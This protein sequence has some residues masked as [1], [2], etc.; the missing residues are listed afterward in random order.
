MIHF[1]SDRNKILALLSLPL[2]RGNV[3]ILLLGSG[4]KNGELLTYRRCIREQLNGIGFVNVSIME[5]ISNDISDRGIN[6]KFA[7]ILRQ[8][9]PNFIFAFFHKGEKMDAVVFEIGYVCCLYGDS[10]KNRLKILHE[11]GY[12]FVNETC[13][14]IDDLLPEISLTVVS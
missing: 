10:I 4:G 7:E 8:Y 12:D 14:Y 11:V 3:K 6:Q 2:T 9:D 5:D 1:Q 13:A